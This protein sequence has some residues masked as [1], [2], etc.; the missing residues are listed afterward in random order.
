MNNNRIPYVTLTISDY[1]KYNTE[2]ES[3]DQGE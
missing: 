1:S 2:N 3:T